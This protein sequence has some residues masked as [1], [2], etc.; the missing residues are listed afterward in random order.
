M[1]KYL[2][3]MWK[4]AG[5]PIHV[6]YH[7]TYRCNS[8]CRSCFLWRELETKNTREEL[9]ADEI[10]KIAKALKG[11]LWLQI[12]GGEPF[13]RE[14]L[15][16]ICNAFGEVDTI[17][18]PTNC[19]NPQQI[20]RQLREILKNITSR[21][22]LTLSLDGLEDMHDEIRG[23][24][25]NFNSVLETYKRVDSLRRQYP[26]FKI[27]VNTVIMRDNQNEIIKIID[28][29][30][31]FFSLDMHAFEFLRGK[32]RDDSS[33]LPNISKCKE[34]IATIKSCISS[35]SYGNGW[36]GMM[37]RKVKLYEQDL[38]LKTLQKNEKQIDCFA[39]R[40]S[41]VINPYGDVYACEIINEKIGNLRD[42][43]Y[44]LNRLWSSKAAG[45][46]RKGLQGCYCTHSCVYLINSL[47]N[48][49]VLSGVLLG[50]R[51]RIDY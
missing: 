15:P 29:V 33:V 37:L 36:K 31:R 42:S 21:L 8:N 2:P 9:G 11:I 49:A 39:G 50:E 5:L 18:I 48:P 51:A 41:A 35:Y 17:A 32:P 6:I 14:D 24:K 25:G 10:R 19:V 45:D 16:Q 38:M 7:C 44:D 22:F 46:I 28:Y 13:L 26:N 27:G 30:K 20:E 3:R 47:F 4:K 34:L 1:L 23:V 12:G 40:L 43:G